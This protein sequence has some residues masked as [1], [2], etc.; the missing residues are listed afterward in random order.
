VLESPRLTGRDR[1][2]AD[3]ASALAGTTAVVIVEGEAGIGKTRLVGE[4]LATPQG[5]KHKTLLAACPP[6]RQPH[7]L[8][9]LVDA[10]RQH[11]VGGVRGLGLSALGGA[12]R[13]LFPEWA[14]DLPPTLEPAEDATAARHRLF[15]ALAELICR[16]DVAV[17]V[18]EDVHWADDATLEFLL[19]LAS[20]QPRP[21]SLVLSYRPEDVPAG[22]LLPRLSRLTAVASGRRITLGPLDAARTAE[23][24]SSMLSDKQVSSGFAAFVHERTEGV[25]LAVE[26][27]VHLMAE[28]GE[29]I[30]HG[31]GWVRRSLAEIQVPP[32]IRET[33]LELVGCLSEDAQ[34]MLRA[35]AVVGEPAIE[36]TLASVTGCGL[37]Q[38][39]AGLSEAITRGLL[40]ES[41]RRMVAFR[42]VLAGRAVYEAI[43]G[44]ERRALHLR[45][46]QV[47][48]GQSPPSP[49]Q[50]ARHFREAGEEAAW[51]RYGE[52]AADLALASGDETAAANVLYDLLIGA[53]LASAD[54]VRLARAQSACSAR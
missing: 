23:L 19:F 8:G 46:G 35:A 50:L 27:S 42:H 26:E 54:V 16:L 41:E 31:D 10:L 12:L 30:R 48:E 45:V 2:L 52:R 5:A 40:A 53:D 39:R 3:L 36:T 34:A 17:L 14:A 4:Y 15:A 6:F 49:V 25:P 22:S 29:L 44:P 24:L 43:P 18:A 7:T 28:R 37:R 9:P 51:C 32:S 1:E 47:L 33:V 11:A 21:V 13:P 38:A 20:G